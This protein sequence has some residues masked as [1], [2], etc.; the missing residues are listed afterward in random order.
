MRNIAGMVS[1]P[2]SKPIIVSKRLASNLKLENFEQENQA[3][4]VS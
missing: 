3:V 1:K 4:Y 2:V